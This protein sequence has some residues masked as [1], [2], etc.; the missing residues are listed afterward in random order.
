MR[1][2][3]ERSQNRTKIGVRSE[4]RVAT[5][6]FFGVSFVLFAAIF[7]VLCWKTLETARRDAAEL[8]LRAEASAPTVFWRESA[9]RD[10]VFAPFDAAPTQDAA[11]RLLFEYFLDV[12]ALAE[13]VDSGPSVSAATAAEPGFRREISAET[14]D[15]Y[16]TTLTAARARF[17]SGDAANASRTRRV[18]DA[19]VAREA[20][21]TLQNWEN[22]AD[23][24]AAAAF[25]SELTDVPTETSA[26]FAPLSELERSADFRDAT[27]FLNA[28]NLVAAPGSVETA[29]RVATPKTLGIW[30]AFH[31]LCLLPGTFFG[32]LFGTDGSI[33]LLLLTKIRRRLGATVRRRA[34][35][36]PFFRDETLAATQTLAVLATVRLLN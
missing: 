10:A 36:A 29:V 24:N 12:D 13:K 1:I 9:R 7:V 23:F 30:G 15:F 6:A 25:L 20:A 27:R 19:Q 33:L 8:G 3:G 21:A 18:A 35:F 28:E 2:I 17:E 34:L 22:D 16:R 31:W 11:T 14:R 4:T 26:P 5:A 32:R